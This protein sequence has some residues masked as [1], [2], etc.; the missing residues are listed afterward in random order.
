MQQLDVNLT[1]PIPSD[2][3]LI[4]KIELQ[5]LRESSLVG[6]YW[7]MK[8]L[9]NRV[10]RKQDWIKENILY[11]SQFRKKLDIEN[12]GF[13]YYPK[14]RGQ[15]WTFQANKMSQFLDKYFNQIFQG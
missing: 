7:N 4:S 12:G 2:Q 6:V 8:D 3:V 14:S 1:I 5:Q 15:N 9:E 11:P 10:G 13:V